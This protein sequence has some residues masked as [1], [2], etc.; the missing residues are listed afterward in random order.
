MTEYCAIDF[1]VL[2]CFIAD[3]GSFRLYLHRVTLVTILC[4]TLLNPH[5]AHFDHEIGRGDPFLGHV[6]KPIST[7]RHVSKNGS[8][9]NNKKKK[10]ISI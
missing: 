1:R 4:V 7:R 10:Q 9:Y 5:L 3:V 2:W 8:F 6:D